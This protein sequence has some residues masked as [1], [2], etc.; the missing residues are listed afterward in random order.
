MGK[1]WDP[2]RSSEL[3]NVPGIFFIVARGPGKASLGCNLGGH[4]MVKTL[5]L[6]LGEQ[7][8]LEQVPTR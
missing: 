1:A 7:F 2:S 4:P 5:A 3:V 6:G 8:R